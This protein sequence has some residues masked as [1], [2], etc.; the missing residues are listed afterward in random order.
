M[1]EL[2][3][4]PEFSVR[5]CNFLFVRA[6][7]NKFD[8]ELKPDY[9]KEMDKLL[10]DLGKEEVASLKGF[11]KSEFQLREIKRQYKQREIEK[12]QGMKLEEHSK[13]LASFANEIDQKF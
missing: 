11:K 4:R 12:R 6:V 7:E 9:V 8:E 1:D 13:R 2:T 10:S 3:F 5:Q